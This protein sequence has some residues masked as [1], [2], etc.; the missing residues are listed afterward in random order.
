MKRILAGLSLSLLFAFAL[1]LSPPF[2]FAWQNGDTIYVN[3]NA[4]GNGSGISWGDAFKSIKEAVLSVNPG[5]QVNLFV[6]QGVYYENNIILSE[7]VDHEL[8]NFFSAR[9]DSD[10][11]P[12]RDL[13]RVEGRQNLLLSGTVQRCSR[14]LG[15]Q[16]PL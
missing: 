8:W 3:K 12:L 10:P 13:I 5:T 16:R 14:E 2:S 6:A 15:P 1:F 4:T 11:K 7:G 9:Y